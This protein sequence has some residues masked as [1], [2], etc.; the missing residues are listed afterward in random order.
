[1]SNDS[2]RVLKNQFNS[3]ESRRND[4]IMISNKWFMNGGWLDYLAATKGLYQSSPGKTIHKSFGSGSQFIPLL[5]L[6]FHFKQ[7]WEP[8]LFQWLQTRM[9]TS[10]ILNT[11]VKQYEMLFVYIT[12]N[13]SSSNERVWILP[14]KRSIEVFFWIAPSRNKNNKWWIL[15]ASCNKK[16]HKCKGGWRMTI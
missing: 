3:C 9:R 16:K 5:F 8:T 2:Y 12:K 10:R 1:M 14:P 7:K 6:E 13:K 15:H 11:Y 4:Y